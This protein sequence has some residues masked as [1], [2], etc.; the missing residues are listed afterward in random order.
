MIVRIKNVQ[1][2]MNGNNLVFYLGGN[3]RELSRVKNAK[4]QQEQSKAKG[5]S[6]KDGNKGLSLE[7]RKQR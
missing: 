2:N 5:A 7:A 3:Q 6:D 4:K 1:L